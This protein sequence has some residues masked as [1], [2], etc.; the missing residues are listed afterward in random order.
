MYWYRPDRSLTAE[1]CAVVPKSDHRL[2]LK[3]EKCVI[4]G[5]GIHVICDDGDTCKRK[6]YPLPDKK[7]N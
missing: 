5:V 3:G 7:R 1:K 6:D 4:F 2:V